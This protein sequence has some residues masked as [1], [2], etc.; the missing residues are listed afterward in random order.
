MLRND[1]KNETFMQLHKLF[2]SYGCP[3]CPKNLFNST[4]YD[5]EQSRIM[6]EKM[7]EAG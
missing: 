5:G 7:A 3:S 4:S 6:R 1:G 2:M